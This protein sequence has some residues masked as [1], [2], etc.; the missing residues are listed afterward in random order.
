VPRAHAAVDSFDRAIDETIRWQLMTEDPPARAYVRVLD[1][2]RTAVPVVERDDVSFRTWTVGAASVA[3]AVLFVVM[4]LRT[5]GLIS[6]AVDTDSPSRGALMLV[7]LSSTS[8]S[9]TP[10]SCSFIRSDSPSSSA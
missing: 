1:A 2:V 10:A 7:W 4:V 9:A 3:A 5:S 8:C 6:L